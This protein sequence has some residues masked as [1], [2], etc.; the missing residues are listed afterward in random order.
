MLLALLP[1]NLTYRLI[2]PQSAFFW[3]CLVVAYFQLGVFYGPTF[4]AVQEL[5]P[6]QVRIASRQM[7][8]AFSMIV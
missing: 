5:C 3:V 2:D 1:V 7:S 6:P 4:S 8:L